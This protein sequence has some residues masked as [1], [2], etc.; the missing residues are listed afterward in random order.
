MLDPSRKALSVSRRVDRVEP[1]REGARRELSGR[2]GADLH[3]RAE[4]TQDRDP[5][6]ERLTV[7]AAN[8]PV[9]FD[10]RRKHHGAHYVAREAW[11]FQFAVCWRPEGTVQRD[12]TGRRRVE[13]VVTGGI[14][15]RGERSIP[16]GL[17][18]E[19]WRWITDAEGPPQ[20]AR[21]RSGHRSS[22]FVDH[23]ASHASW[24]AWA[25]A[26]VLPWL[27]AG[28]CGGFARR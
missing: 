6:V 1:G 8:R 27:C 26:S 11:G 9:H 19:D 12:E 14:C 15:G 24:S 2:P 3:V 5:C 23:G 18:R 20:E 21:S 13:I 7:L 28:R 17:D 10:R 4:L 22:M 25:T 16:S